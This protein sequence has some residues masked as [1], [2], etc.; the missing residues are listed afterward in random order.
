[1]DQS[2]PWIK[3][4]SD[5]DAHGE[6]GKIYQDWKRAN[7]RGDRPV[8]PASSWFYSEEP[9]AIPWTTNSA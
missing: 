8:I 2:G 1:M 7:P 9:Q 4:V 3:W 5:E 6:V